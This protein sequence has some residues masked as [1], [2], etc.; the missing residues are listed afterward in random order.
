MDYRWLNLK[1]RCDAF[2]LPRIDES[3]DVLGGAKSTIGLASRYHQVAVHEK[4]RHK[5]ESTM[6]FGLYEFLKLSL[7]LFNA[8]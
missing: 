8:P 1:T 5:T 3:R 2:P 4:N 7:A 6:L